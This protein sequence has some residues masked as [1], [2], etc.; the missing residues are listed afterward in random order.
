MTVANVVA[1]ALA[2]IVLAFAPVTQATETDP[3]TQP[4]P[5]EPRRRAVVA[6]P[7]VELQ[8]LDDT[9]SFD[10]ARFTRPGD[11]A[12]RTA[13][14][15][16]L[17]SAAEAELDAV[18]GAT[19]ADGAVAEAPA[20][21]DG[22]TGDVPAAEAELH[23]LLALPADERATSEDRAARAHADPFASDARSPRLAH[24]GGAVDPGPGSGTKV[25][26]AEA[27]SGAQC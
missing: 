21:D 13:P 12:R 7:D 6:A 11:A 24:P 18:A 17:R 1:A 20:W 8:A 10:E 14:Q 16:G 15:N 25:R 23:A 9:L 26:Q 19:M 3:A 27:C 5:D 2:S 22:L 4:R